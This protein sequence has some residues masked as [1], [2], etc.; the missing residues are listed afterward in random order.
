VLLVD[1]P[2]RLSPVQAIER[3]RGLDSSLA[4]RR[5]GYAGRLDPLADGLLVLLL[6]E[7]NKQAHEFNHLDK[8]YEVEVVFGVQTDSFDLLGL[9]EAREVVHDEAAFDRAVKDLEGTRE[10]PYPRWSSVRVRGRPA[11][12]WAHRGETPEGGWPS[13]ERTVSS[14]TVIERGTVDGGALVDGAIEDVRGVRGAFRQEVLIARWAS[15][16]GALAG[17]AL[18]RARLAV[19]CSSGTFMR[20]LAN[21]LGESLGTGACATVIHR[22][23]AGPFHLREAMAL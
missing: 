23:R 12:Y 11:F 1:K 22:T 15:L 7:R 21:S 19:E 6:D 2:R 9:A 18:P 5:I 17:R 14:V 3:A 20:S 13:R 8:R 4:R 16:R 10:Q